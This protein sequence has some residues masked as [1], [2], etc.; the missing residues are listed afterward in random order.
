MT[1]RE[2][3]QL[4]GKTA[5]GVTGFSYTSATPDDSEVLDRLTKK[6]FALALSEGE[7]L[8]RKEA[9]QRAMENLAWARA[10]IAKVSK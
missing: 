1:Q 9:R 4:N 5:R 10:E 3:Y 6:A 2:Q 8:T 7:V